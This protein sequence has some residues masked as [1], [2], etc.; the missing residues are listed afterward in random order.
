[1][2]A[3]PPGG[4]S[5]DPASLP[6]F[7]Y[8]HLR[9]PLPK[10]IHSG[11]FKN[12][13]S[14]YFLMR[15]SYDGYVS[16]TGMFKATFP[17]AAAD[18]EEEERRY[19]KALE[20]TSPEETAGNVWI[21]PEQA[22]A[23]ADEY[24]IT[25][26]IQALLDPTEVPPS[27]GNDGSPPKRIS[28]PP[29]FQGAAISPLAPPTPTSLPRGSRSKRSVSPTK[30]A[31]SKRGQASP[32]KKTTRVSSSQTSTEDTPIPT[33]PASAIVESVSKEPAVVLAPVE[34]EP[35]V[36]IN[37]DQDVK[38][39][40]DGKEI[41]HTNVEVELPLA[42]ELPSAEA[43]AKMVAEA[44]EMVKAAAETVAASAPAGSSKKGKR[45]A[46]EIAADADKE[47][48]DAAEPSAKKVK[49]EVELR[50]ERVRKRALLGISAT[51]AVGYV[52]SVPLRRLTHA[53][54]SL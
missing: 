23:L 1:M 22:I 25:P 52:L 18:E 35:K 33:P 51:L 5:I 27:G 34:E 7:D 40:K 47:N 26:W 39:D 37:I 48:E 24:D 2:V 41:T 17:Y 8:A 50:K 42:G 12:S 31:G 6:A 9:A 4:A 16:A 43:A 38:V 29:K 44:K 19:I 10:G 20:T 45:K 54:Q 13:P 53:N 21:S 28:A 14:S 3:A 49:T 46:A 11:I 36:K 30:S 15:R 32:R